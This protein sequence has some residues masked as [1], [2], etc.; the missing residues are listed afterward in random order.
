MGSKWRKAKLALG[1]NLCVYVPRTIDDG[2]YSPPLSERG[3]DAALLSPSVSMP[4]T[5]T[6]SSHG[7]RLS[8]SMSRS[9]KK[10]CSI[11][12]TTMKR[13]EGHAIFTAECSHSFHFHCIASN[14]KHGNQICPVCRAK[15]KE[16]PLQGPT[17]DPP[18][19]R[20]RINPVDWS[21]K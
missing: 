16:I 11:C 7:L 4:M 19:G 10:T 15:W 1:M 21:S 18:P 12:L 17:F 2:D 14:V 13:G 6:P 5:P 9:S 8:K 20:A 3:S